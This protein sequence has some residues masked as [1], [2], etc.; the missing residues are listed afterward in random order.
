M[1][2]DDALYPANGT[3]RDY[4]VDVFGARAQVDF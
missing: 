3:D 4:A 1:D 2:Y